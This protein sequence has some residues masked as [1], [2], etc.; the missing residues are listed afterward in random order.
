MPGS[1]PDNTPIARIELR[2]RL[3]EIRG[4]VFVAL[5]LSLAAFVNMAGIA[6]SGEP[7]MAKSYA[8]TLFGILLIVAPY[9]IAKARIK[10]LEME[11]E[12]HR[13]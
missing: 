12:G 2:E 4:S 10:K 3:G 13:D 11:L 1:S 7:D 8:F 9:M 5:L 6:L